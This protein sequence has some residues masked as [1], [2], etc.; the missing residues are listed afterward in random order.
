MTVHSKEIS[1]RQSA[2]TAWKFL[3]FT[4]TAV[5]ADYILVNVPIPDPYDVPLIL[6]VAVLPSIVFVRPHKEHVLQ[7]ELSSSDSRQRK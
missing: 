2:L 6:N 4:F 1:F 3:A 7:A 5:L